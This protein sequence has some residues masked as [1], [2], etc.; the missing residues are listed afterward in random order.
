MKLDL[1][2]LERLE[3][4]ATFVP[5]INGPSGIVQSQRAPG[6]VFWD[7]NGSNK[8]CD[9]PFIAAA[10]N[11]MPALLAEVKAAREWL[12]AYAP[13]LGVTGTYDVTKVNKAREAYRAI[14]EANS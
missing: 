4:A 8:E 10:R 3:K 7:D 2:E 13:G 6:F 12:A 11:A 9:Y 14:V 1:D 5:W